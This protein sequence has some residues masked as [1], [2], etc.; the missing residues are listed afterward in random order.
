MRAAKK[1]IHGLCCVLDGYHLQKYLVRLTSHMKDS[2]DDAQRELR[3][4]IRKKTKAEFCEIVE[5]L[6]DALPEGQIESGTERL[7]A[8]RD[9]ILSNWSAARMRLLHKDRVIGSSTEGHVSYV[10]STRMSSRP[11]GWSRKGTGKITQLRAYYYN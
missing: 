8:S 9:Y 4:A 10:L 6:K 5:R 7:E 3:E 1:R 2:T 11:M